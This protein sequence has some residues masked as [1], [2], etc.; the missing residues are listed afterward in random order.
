VLQTITATPSPPP[1]SVMN[2]RRF[3]RSPRRRARGTIRG[4]KVRAPWQ[5]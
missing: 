3:T 2:S 4:L 5:S 1:L